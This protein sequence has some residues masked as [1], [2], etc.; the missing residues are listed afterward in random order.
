MSDNI[1]DIIG[2]LNGLKTKDNPVSM[3][4]EPVYESI[5]PQD[6]TPAVDSLEEKYQNF[7]IEETAKRSQQKDA[8]ISRGEPE[9]VKLLNKARLERPS[10]ASDTEALAYQMVKANKELEKANAAN[11]EQE[12]KI[13]DLQAK[14]T[15]LPTAKSVPA[16]QSMPTP[17]AAARPTAAAPST[18]S[19]AKP[20]ATI[21]RM[22]TPGTAEVPAQAPATAEVPATATSTAEVPADT[23]QTKDTKD[24]G[25]TAKTQG[26]KG[27]AITT[28]GTTGGD[29]A[30]DGEIN[31]SA[32]GP[33]VSV[34]DPTKNQKKVSTKTQNKSNVT[35]ISPQSELPLLKRA[36][37]KLEEGYY[38]SQNIKNEEQATLDLVNI[39]PS[40][41]LTTKKDYVNYNNEKLEAML[42]DPALTS[43]A[44]IYPGTGTG[45]GYSTINLT[46]PM[47]D[48]LKSALASIKNPE[49][50]RNV[51][52]DV[53][54]NRETASRYLTS[55]QGDKELHFFYDVKSNEAGKA[56]NLGL[57]AN[58]QGRWYAV[59]QENPNATKTFGKPKT[60]WVSP[61][62]GKLAGTQQENLGNDTM[63][64]NI[65]TNS[66]LEGVRQVED[67]KL[68]E[69]AKPD[70]L[71][72]DKDGDTD[73]PMKSA[74]KS[75]KEH[76]PA[77]PDSDAVTKRKR[78]QA[79]KDKQEDE[80]AE[81]GEYDSKS[82]SRVVKGRAYGGAAQKDDEDKDLDESGLQYYTGKKKYGKE[83]MTALSKAGREGASEEELSRIKDK[84]K[85]EDI[86]LNEKAVSKQQQKFMGMVHAV[87][88]GKMKAP[89]KLIAKT[90]KS[91]SDKAAGDFA[92]TKHK[93]L[94][95]KVTEG[96]D[97]IRNHPIYTTKE[98]WDH[99]AEELAEQEMMQPSMME[100]PMVD[101]QQ[102]L[103][104]IAKLAGL[105][106]KM[107]AKSVC[108]S[109][110]CEKCECN[111]NL[112]PM[113]PA[114]SASPLTHTEEGMG[115]TM[116]E[117]QEAMSRK[118][119][120]TMANKIKNMDDRDLAGEIC[121]TFAEMAKADNPRFKE[122]MFFAACDVKNP[123][124]VLVDE[125]AMDEGN[126]FTKA[127][128]DAIAQG[129]DT[130]SV[131]GKTYNVSG[132]ISDEKTQVESV[133][134]DINVNITANGEQDALNLL[135]KLSGMAEVPQVTG[136]AIPM[137]DESS[138]CG[139]CGTS[140]CG[141]EESVEEERDIELANTPH[142]KIAPIT[143]VTTDAGGGLG[144]VKKQYPLAA[145]RGANP[146][147]EQVEESL[148]KAYETM[149]ND[150]KA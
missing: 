52:I 40:P 131:S 38:K 4:A 44:L 76:E 43:V 55:A 50:H 137:G 122:D 120:R 73:E 133:N 80:R 67:K 87:Q 149:I 135:R 12:T 2:K 13:A 41:V 39:P 93:G 23:A 81:K 18:A 6:I 78:L 83:G 56:F 129:K 95:T 108:P 111:E 143:A 136:I 124:S 147:E 35:S 91:M 100:A 26:D 99:Y 138:T 112:D 22:P 46:R 64:E 59:G 90:A 16:A 119:Y 51:A 60:L 94:P 113:V 103:D 118:D 150:V 27:L 66:I 106:P 110:N 127:R 132:D 114:D 134:E 141:C 145:N 115:C 75:A 89:S 37:E 107:E 88:K 92:A 123:A 109:C 140:P 25:D 98:A 47:F 32:L 5:D 105:A 21:L 128:L 65:K 102:E 116:E 71:D 61:P 31:V 54:S 48:K 144:G 10:A 28:T 15:Q 79:L 72:L 74:A 70:F 139:S 117:L 45:K 7:L 84:Y 126:E 57:K 33:N 63:Q 36:G 148:W 53:L 69:A 86:D 9:I 125:E 146:I 11:D 19:A 29:A 68:R 104:E 20:S 101:V 62:R 42:G 77:K 34:L 142:E 1:Y 130:F 17:A 14:I 3:S 96:K 121:Q 49:M 82:S 58:P 8:E 24:T 30:N 85:K 97:A